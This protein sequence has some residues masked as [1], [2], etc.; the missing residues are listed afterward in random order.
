MRRA[1]TDDEWIRHLRAGA[2]AHAAAFTWEACAAGTLEGYA[3]VLGEA[4]RR[5][6]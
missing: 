5:A 3:K 1:A 4:G 6:A 2:E